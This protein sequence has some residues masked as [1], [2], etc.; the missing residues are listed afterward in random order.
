MLA[1]GGLEVREHR[2]QFRPVLT[3]HLLG[4]FGIF[5]RRFLFH[6]VGEREQ[7]VQRTQDTGGFGFEER[8]S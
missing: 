2:S 8:G 5:V 6:R 1:L 4:E 7:F 3:P